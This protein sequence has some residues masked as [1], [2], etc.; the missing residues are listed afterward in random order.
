LYVNYLVLPELALTAG[1]HGNKYG[2]AQLVTSTSGAVL[3]NLDKYAS[4]VVGAKY[5]APGWGTQVAGNYHS[6]KFTMDSGESIKV[7]TMSFGIK[8]PIDS[9]AIGVQ[10][11]YSK[12]TNFTKGRDKAFMLM[13]D[14]NFSKR[15]RLYLRA[16]VVKDERGN[17]AYTENTA[18]NTAG[19]GIAGGPGPLLASLGS[20]ET[21]FFSA[22]GSNLDATTRVVAIGIRHQF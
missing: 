16:G 19:L 5:T 6:G 22:A 12:F 11:A 20:L 7:D 14:Y 8:H 10:L 9:M 17:L 2:N 21:P 18:L 13:G 3:F 15:T 1:Y 4:Y